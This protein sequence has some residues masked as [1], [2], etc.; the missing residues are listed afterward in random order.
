MQESGET[1]R[2]RLLVRIALIWSGII[3]LRL[4]HLQVISH[5][6]LK[7]TARQQQEREM[8]IAV[9]RGTIFDRSGKTLAKSLTLDS[10]C[11][12]PI[13]VPD[14]QVAAGILAGVLGLDSAA[15]QARIEKA[16]SAHRGFMWVQRRI[17]REQSQRLRSFN[18]EWIELRQETKRVYP[19]GQLASHVIG[20]V[21]F[22]ERGNSGL[23]F[24]LDDDLQGQAGEVRL[25]TD[26]KQRA[27][28]STTEMN[29]VPG[30]DI[31]LTIDSRIQYSAETELEKAALKSGAKSGSV[32]V[33]K[34]TTGEVL[35]LANWP[36]FD[37]NGKIADPHA[38]TGRN[39]L[40]VTSP[41]EPGSVFK[42]VTVAAALETTR[43]RPESMIDC[44]RGS[45]QVGNHTVHE[46]HG[47]YGMLSVAD[48]LAK[49][50]NIGAI[51][52]AKV[53]GQ[54]N[55]H[56]YVT[57]FGFGK[58]TGVPVPSESGGMFRPLKYWGSMSLPSIAMGHEVSVTAMQLAQGCL[59]VASGGQLI[60]PQLI[61]KRQRPG[62]PEHMEPRPAPRQV[63]KPETAIT[64]RALMEGVV[65]HGTGRNAR[66]NGYTSGG[67]TGTAKIYD[68]ATR[69]Y[70]HFYNGSFIGFAP[71]KNPEIVVVVTLNRT[72][73][74][75]GYGG[76]VAGPVFHAVAT[77]ALRILDVPKDLP[78]DT[79]VEQTLPVSE[80]SVAG[81]EPE[82]GSEPVSPVPQGLD[83][84]PTAPAQTPF[85]G[86]VQPPD[87]DA[88][89]G[90]RVPNFRG[91][92]MRD[93][94]QKATEEGIAVE[95]VG[96][97][98]ARAQAPEPGMLLP[99]GER[100]RVQFDR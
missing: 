58:P 25:V 92:T 48:V 46:A 43:L 51:E 20:S 91:R 1:K 93:V 17:T 59:V 73:G 67:K 63:I 77:D 64:M 47:G 38:I 81:L 96:H 52:I 85:F 8:E 24:A 98:V 12:N 40:A 89:A 30:E 78:E 66:L 62:E 95:L 76:A 79:D 22:E 74:G 70:T 39:N 65:L 54:E 97:G 4:V 21:D 80:P 6:E 31:T 99:A 44:H 29:G 75:A 87:P 55:L 100:V 71:V 90:Q 82:P 10:V 27:Y 15:L 49:S 94:I 88:P 84:A 13:R 41:Y 11:V 26:V 7:E 86:P 19:N 14:A 50:S 2:V 3:L 53:V 37:P 57:R 34:V 72:T 33:L 18:L 60:R 56:E 28:E 5:D 42:V 69:S 16:A 32:I 61:L 9:P 68:F 36:T 35:A 23:E 45:L 83:E